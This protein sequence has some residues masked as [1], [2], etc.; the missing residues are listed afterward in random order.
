MIDLLR[1][2]GGGFGAYFAPSE[3]TG[4]G[5]QSYPNVKLETGLRGKAPIINKIVH[6]GEFKSPKCKS[7]VL[8][9]E[10]GK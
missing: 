10:P 8:W 2:Y 6:R 1:N 9:N 3:N 7:E 5:L 4:K